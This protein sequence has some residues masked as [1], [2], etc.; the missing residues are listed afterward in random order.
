[1]AEQNKVDL[2]ALRRFQQA[3]ATDPDHTLVPYRTSYK[4]LLVNISRFGREKPHS[5]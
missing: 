2:A 1:M 5:P 3:A 4:E